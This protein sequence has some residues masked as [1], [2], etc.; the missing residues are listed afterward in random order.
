MCIS[1]EEAFTHFYKYRFKNK[2]KPTKDLPLERGTLWP[3]DVDSKKI[4]GK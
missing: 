3:R 4:S 2:E 1:K